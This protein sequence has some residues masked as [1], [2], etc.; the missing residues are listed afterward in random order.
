MKLHSSPR[1]PYVRKVMIT[2]HETGTAAQLEMVRT[3]VSVTGPNTDLIRI[4]PLSKIPTLETND[5]RVLYDSIVICEYL[6]HLGATKVFPTDFDT[7]IE[8]LRWHALG[9]GLTDLLQLWRHELGRTEAIRSKPHL[10][11]FAANVTGIVHPL[12]AAA[13]VLA[14]RRFDIG[15]IGLGMGIGYADFRFAEFDWRQSRPQLAAWFAQLDAR[16]S[17]EKTRPP[18]DG[19]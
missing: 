1:S 13:P 17:F 11:A 14:A 2:A 18:V 5:G 9:Q 8:A 10:E 6:D 3:P 19:S 16:P 4:N 12:E 7:R 15:H